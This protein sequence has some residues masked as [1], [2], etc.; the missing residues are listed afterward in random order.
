MNFSPS[1]GVR[2]GYIKDPNWPP[3]RMPEDTFVAQRRHLRVRCGFMIRI[4]G[5]SL[6]PTFGDISVGGAKFTLDSAVG[7]A[8]E[9]LAG[10]FAAAAQ[11]VDV[12]KM[13]GLFVYRVKFV[14]AA[15]GAEVF[16]AA[17]QAS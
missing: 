10:D 5:E 3:A 16:E 14:D 1:Y 2:A 6:A 15:A 9:V 4:A 12:K 8:L 7:S 17:L 11:V 13:P